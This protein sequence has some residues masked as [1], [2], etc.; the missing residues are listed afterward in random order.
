MAEIAMT[1]STYTRRRTLNQH[2]DLIL[3]RKSTCLEAVP[4]TGSRHKPARLLQSRQHA[5]MHPSK[6]RRR[7]MSR[8]SVCLCT[9]C[10]EK[11]NTVGLRWCFRSGK[12]RTPTERST[13]IHRARQSLN[14]TKRRLLRCLHLVCVC[15]SDGKT[16][17]QRSQHTLPPSTHRP[18]FM[19]LLVAGDPRTNA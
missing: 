9:A 3:F 13:K 7:N 16:G 14:R 2:Q 12:N 4:S 8:S 1:L 19:P 17:T 15:V 11:K 5:Q 18:H 10:Q 6:R